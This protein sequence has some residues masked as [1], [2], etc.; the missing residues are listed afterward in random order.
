MLPIVGSAID[1]ATWHEYGEAVRGETALSLLMLLQPWQHMLPCHSGAAGYGL[2]PYLADDAWNA[3]FLGLPAAQAQGMLAAAAPSK[4]KYC[5]GSRCAHGVSYCVSGCAGNTVA[6]YSVVLYP[7][8][9]YRGDSHGVALWRRQHHQHLPFRTLVRGWQGWLEK[10]EPFLS[11]I[12]TPVVLM[13]LI[14]GSWV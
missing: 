12:S 3:S 9:R 2:D 11:P 4:A 8:G 5:T 6:P 1:A 13:T 14:Y 7:P 10:T